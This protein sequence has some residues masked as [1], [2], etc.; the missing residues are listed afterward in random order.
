MQFRLRRFY[1]GVNTYPAPALESAIMEA[2]ASADGE[3]GDAQAQ[4]AV[5]PVSP[6]KYR[7]ISWEVQAVQF[8]GSEGHANG[9]INWLNDKA[10]TRA[11]NPRVKKDGQSLIVVQG[12]E[13]EAEGEVLRK[14]GYALLGA[15]GAWTRF[16]EP[17]TFGKRYEK[18]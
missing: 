3:T 5:S 14:G 16:M 7:T 4:Q 2:P 15:N 13:N 1:E 17:R 18:A 10:D 8:D 6:Q 9:I 11:H 12:N